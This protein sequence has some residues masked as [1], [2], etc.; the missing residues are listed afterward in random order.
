MN[1]LL[2]TSLGQTS[3]GLGFHCIHHL[4]YIIL[5]TFDVSGISV[6]TMEIPTPTDAESVTVNLLTSNA[7]QRNER[8]IW[9]PL[10]ERWIR[11]GIWME[12]FMAVYKYL[13]YGVCHHRIIP[14]SHCILDTTDIIPLMAIAVFRNIKWI[15]V[16]LW[17]VRIPNCPVLLLATFCPTHFESWADDL[18]IFISLPYAYIAVFGNS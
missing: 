16:A 13:T 8:W 6:Y 4:Y 18:K 15:P 1:V 10:I 17:S 3:Q 14:I 5:I 7:M 12:I 2:V 9:F 11:R